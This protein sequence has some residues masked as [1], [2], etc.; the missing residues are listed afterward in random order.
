MSDVSIYLDPP[1]HHQ[2]GDRLF[3]R[4]SNPYAGDDILAPYAAIRDHFDAKGIP[5]RTA[6]NLDAASDDSTKVVVSFGTPDRLPS[7]SVRKYEAWGRRDDVVLSAFFAMEC[8]IVEPGMFR[9][10][11]RLSK[12]FNHIMSWSDT[13]S[14][15]QFTG[16]PVDVEPFFWPQSFDAVH[17]EIWSRDDRG[18]L[19]LMNA[20]K[21]PRLYV[22]ELYT[23][24]LRAVAYFQQFDEIHLYGRNWDQPPM[25]V[26]KT[27][28]PWVLRRWGTRL[29][30]WKYALVPDPLYVSARAAWKG[31][32]VS[33]SD[34]ISRYR[35][36]IC[37]EN[38][39]L[40]GW[41]TEKIFDCFFAGTIPVYW[42][43]PEI[44]DRVPA[45]CFIDMRD[46]SGYEELRAYLHAL[47]EE[48]VQAYRDAAR[49]YLESGDFDPFRIS[50]WVETMDSLVTADVEARSSGV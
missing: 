43:A 28:T 19:L 29:W 13:E 39:V 48:E 16:T 5:V 41:I 36:A 40:R 26:G 9:A 35:F 42:G 34:T 47:T 1:T 24:R 46:F 37:F 6:D 8:P 23:E 11:P 44:L 32:A 10:L 3:D 14:L 2:F 30:G 45:A 20:N 25:R 22:D 31:A 17:D 12:L 4:E 33:K 7:H 50:R 49:A 15:L 38:S 27:R 18:F 21:R